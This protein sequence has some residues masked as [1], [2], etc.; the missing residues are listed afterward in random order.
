[1][2]F[3]EHFHPLGQINA[4][5]SDL[6]A[7]ISNLIWSLIGANKRIGQIVTDRVPFARLLT[8][9]NLLF[10][11][12]CEDKRLCAE[13]K[14]LV[15]RTDKIRKRR[16]KFVHSVWFTNPTTLRVRRVKVIASEGEMETEDLSVEE[17]T[18]FG[19]DIAFS[20]IDLDQFRIQDSDPSPNSPPQPSSG[21]QTAFQAPNS[22]F[23]NSAFGL[24]KPLWC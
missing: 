5:F 7:D 9:L 21:P 8:M 1:M 16:N 15:K 18:K 23:A 24:G 11:E 19:N 22:C 13:L 4:N 17:M 12:R 14:K 6:E 20:I 10:E 3:A 2:P